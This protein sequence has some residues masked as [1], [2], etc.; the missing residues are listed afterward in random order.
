VKPDY[1]AMLREIARVVPFFE[2]LVG[3][4]GAALAL[5]IGLL[6][7]VRR[8]ARLHAASAPGGRV[9]GIAIGAAAFYVGCVVLATIAGRARLVRAFA[10]PGTAARVEGLSD[11]LAGL[12]N[13]LPFGLET[14]FPIVVLAACTLAVQAWARCRARGEVRPLSRFV[15]AALAV[16]GFG[17]VPLGIG[18]I[19]YCALLIKSTAGVAGVDPEMKALMLAKGFEETEPVLAR[20]CAVA[21]CGLVATI[22]GIGI[23]WL[24][25]AARDAI[26][27]DP[28]ASRRARR[29]GAVG[30]A[31]ALLL[32][33]ASLSYRAERRAPWPEPARAAALNYGAFEASAID[34]P[35]PLP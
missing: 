31:G 6:V 1:V 29:L 15:G 2:G 26:P 32:V 13:A 30:F 4:W 25:S 18:V 35:D 16:V 21:A 12:L 14:A 24:R 5:E 10:A 8:Q 11:G 19:G 34:G 20:W 33:A 17:L 28:R 23:A 22:T 27:R 7:R 9:E 3:V